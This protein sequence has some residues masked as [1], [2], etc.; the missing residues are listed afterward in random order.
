[1]DNNK[2]YFFH[3]TGSAAANTSRGRTNYNFDLRRILGAKYDKFDAFNIALEAFVPEGG[4][5]VGTD[6]YVFCIHASGLP[7]M[8]NYYDSIQDYSD[9]RVLEVVQWVLPGWNFLKNIHNT[10]FYKPTQPIQ[11]SFSTFITTMTGAFANQLPSS[12]FGLIFSIT[13]IDQCRVKRIP[14][15]FPVYSSFGKA[16]P[17]LVLNSTFARSIDPIDATATKKRIFTFDN[18][19]WRQ[20]IGSE[21]YDKYNKFSLV[22]R[23][24]FNQAL[25]NNF[26]NGFLTFTLHLSGSNLVFETPSISQYQPVNSEYVQLHG[27]NIPVVIGIVRLSQNDSYVE[28]VFYKPTQDIGSITISHGSRLAVNFPTPPSGPNLTN[29]TEYP[30][31]VAHFEIIPVVDV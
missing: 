2:S 7:F 12:S 24:V 13:G 22:T 18:V 10:P 27:G 30:T 29:N 31:I 15:P 25:I 21:L 5:Y 28:N 23:R 14:R 8:T 4:S 6:F 17:T 19:N 1:M 20:V 11:S 16:N 9:A 26:G 3:S